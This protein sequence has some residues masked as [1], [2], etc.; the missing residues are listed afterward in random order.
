[1][2]FNM[3][4]LR[5]CRLL[6]KFF[7]FEIVELC[8]QVNHC[9]G[10][11]EADVIEAKSAFA[12][13]AQNRHSNNPKVKQAKEVLAK[14]HLPEKS[15]DQETAFLNIMKGKDP[16]FP[17]GAKGVVQAREELTELLQL[18]AADAEFK[19]EIET[20][21]KSLRE[22]LC[23]FALLANLRTKV[24]GKKHEAGPCMLIGAAARA[25]VISNH[26]ICVLVLHRAPLS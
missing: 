25:T 8:Q 9:F 21:V 2:L 16:Q 4:I 19:P 1:M 26:H 24:M 3:L 14:C 13:A 15:N 11:V 6:C 20:V 18:N 23:A 22:L 7:N 10:R 17:Q 5:R 12:T